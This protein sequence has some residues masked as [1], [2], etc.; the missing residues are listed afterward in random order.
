[1]KS[2][3][4]RQKYTRWQRL[5]TALYGRFSV[6]FEAFLALGL[7]VV[8]IT[9]NFLYYIITLHEHNPIKALAGALALVVLQFQNIDRFDQTGAALI[10]FN[11]FFTVF[12]A[13]SLLNAIRGLVRPKDIHVR[14]RAL[15]STLRHHVIVCGLGRVGLRVAQ[16]LVASGTQVVI[17]EAAWGSE[18]VPDAVDMAIPVIAGDATRSATLEK[19]GIQRAKG[20]IACI[21]GDLTNLEIALL[22]RSIRKDIR[23]I[24]RSFRDDFDRGLERRYGP[25]TAFSASALAAPTFGLATV[26]RNLEYVIPFGNTHLGVIQVVLPRNRH[27]SELVS[28]FERQQQLRILLDRVEKGEQHCVVLGPLSVLATINAACAV[29]PTQ[30]VAATGI[31]PW[32]PNDRV[33]ICGLGKIGYRV[34]RLLHSL[35]PHLQIV[36]ITK[37]DESRTFAR[38]I[39]R[40]ERVVVKHGDARDAD[41]LMEAGMQHA[42]AV[43]AV[44]SDDLTNLQIG[45]EAR[46]LRPDIH[47]VL[48]VFSDSLADQLVDLFG[49]HT[50][51]SVSNLAS[52]TLAANA[53]LIGVQGA[54]AINDNVY[55]VQTVT[56]GKQHLLIGRSSGWVLKQFGVITLLDDAQGVFPTHDRVLKAGEKV[57]LLGTLPQLT[58]LSH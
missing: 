50:T 15:A 51:Y 5:R 36:V 25:Q 57:T 9:G 31:S 58:K 37:P 53:S 14:Q 4:I 35:T 32:S 29:L 43:A 16:R 22:A 47:L 24:V 49:I 10:V 1:M 44:T 40:L 11:V 20:V 42:L 28:A 34:L 17:V 6:F 19:A 46:R 12:F 30:P 55:T 48:R 2:L 33:I 52:P 39:D 41:L 54:F 7:L 56:L 3:N 27:L 13:Q 26:V 23:V 21:D 38:Q 18:Y 8:V 45:L